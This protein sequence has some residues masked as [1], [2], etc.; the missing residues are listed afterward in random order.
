MID[1]VERAQKDSVD[2]RNNSHMMW[3]EDNQ[4]VGFS[5]KLMP[6]RKWNCPI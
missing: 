3:Q 2:Q 5:G 6:Y 1:G 4:R